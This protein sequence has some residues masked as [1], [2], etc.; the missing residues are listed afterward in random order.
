M[1][2]TTEFIIPAIANVTIISS[3]LIEVDA[4]NELEYV[5]HMDDMGNT[6]ITDL[7]GNVMDTAAFDKLNAEKSGDHGKIYT[8]QFR[9]VNVWR[10]EELTTEWRWERPMFIHRVEDKVLLINVD[11]SANGIEIDGEVDEVDMDAEVLYR[12]MIHHFQDQGFEFLAG[13]MN[14]VI[15]LR[16][17]VKPEHVLGKMWDNFLAKNKGSDTQFIAGMLLRPGLQSDDSLNLRLPSLKATAEMDGVGIV[18][19]DAQWQQVLAHFGLDKRTAAL[20]VTYANPITGAAFKGTVSVETEGRPAGT[21][22]ETWKYMTSAKQPTINLKFMSVMNS[23]FII[24]SRSSINQQ[25]SYYEFTPAQQTR[26]TEDYRSALDNISDLKALAGAGHVIT[27]GHL[28][29]QG[30]NPFYGG[31]GM[32]VNDIRRNMALKAC[33]NTPVKGWMLLTQ[34]SLDLHHDEIRVPKR[35]YRVFKRAQK[36]GIFARFNGK[37]V[38]LSQRN[39]TLPTGGSLQNYKIVGISKGNVIEVGMRA[40][41]VERSDVGLGGPA[42]LIEYTQ[43]GSAQ[44][45]DH[46]G[47]QKVLYDPFWVNE[48]LFDFAPKRVHNQEKYKPEKGVSEG[49]DVTHRIDMLIKDVT[50]AIGAGDS[51]A[52]QAIDSG[53]A[54]PEFL[55]QCSDAIQRAITSKK[56]PVEQ[57][58]VVRPQGVTPTAACAFQ[59]MKKLVQGQDTEAFGGHVMLGA[60]NQALS[61]ADMETP[62]IEYSHS[63]I[64]EAFAL[65]SN[66][67]SKAAVAEALDFARDML[68]MYD[69]LNQARTQ[70]TDQQQ[71]QELNRIIKNIRT[72]ELPMLVETQGIFAMWKPQGFVGNLT[73]VQNM[74]RALMALA[75][76][77]LAP[78]ALRLWAQSMDKDIL[79]LFLGEEH[80][81]RSGDE[82][83]LLSGASTVEFTGDYVEVDVNDEGAAFQ[84]GLRIGRFAVD[85]RVPTQGKRLFKRVGGTARRHI[86]EAA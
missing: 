52:R 27:A 35:V 72:V 53:L 7:R 63:K 50:I 55:A 29:A 75:F 8:G 41:K 47:D 34:P 71:R 23:D 4:D 40:E 6:I 66:M 31:G 5:A 30:L 3:Q 36:L 79:T 18:F 43:W 21:Y 26:V 48:R 85:K 24:N 68:G 73:T 65:V 62:V 59:Q 39:P 42:G 38:G 69:A 13:K 12:R 10:N 33:R 54:T 32:E 19:K 20:Q 61:I 14:K 80:G 45:G 9:S 67:F 86:L 22:T 17:G 46:D 84:N 11:D 2:T 78:G 1:N 60:V 51:A 49:V 15:F 28:V 16:P 57:R 81:G 82:F 58:D 64:K 37:M 74:R 25:L 56:H 70:S 44:L 76:A 83:V 77:H